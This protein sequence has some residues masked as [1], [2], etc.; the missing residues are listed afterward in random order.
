MW[1]AQLG[2]RGD[3]AQYKLNPLRARTEDFARFWEETT[4]ADFEIVE[5]ALCARLAARETPAALKID[6]RDQAVR[7]L[8]KNFGC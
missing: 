2:S 3:D 1:S 5:L 7:Y 4:C 6:S 8:V